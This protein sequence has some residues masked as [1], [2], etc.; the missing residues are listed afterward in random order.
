MT[1]RRFIVILLDLIATV[2]ALLSSFLLRWGWDDFRL[3]SDSILTATLIALPVALASYWAFG[4]A[5]TPWKYFSASDLRRIAMAVWVPALALVAVDYLSKSSILV[6]RTVPTIYWFVQVFLLAGARLMYRSYR[7]QRQ[8]RRAFKGVHRMPVLIAG[9]DDEAENLIRR[10]QRD[11]ARPMEVV[12]LLSPKP[13]QVGERMLGIPVLGSFADL[14]AV[15]AALS[16]RNVQARR[17]IVTRDSLRQ[18]PDIDTLLGAARKVGIAAVRSTDTM[19]EVEEHGA[20]LKLAP[21]SIDD[22]LG[23]SSRDL[24]LSSIRDLVGGRRIAVTGAGGSIGSELCRQIA[25][26]QPAGLMLFEQSELA[27]YTI[28]KELRRGTPALETVLHLGSVCDRADI[29]AAF[30]SFRP[31]LVFHAAALKHVDLVE[32]HPV[33][34]ARTNTLGTAYVAEAALAVDARCAVFISTDKA[35]HPVSVLGATKRAGELVWAA[36]DRK[37]QE[38]GR[39]TRFMSVRFGNVLGSSGSVIPLFTEQLVQGGPITVTDPEVERYFMTISEAV[40]LVLMASALGV[41]CAGPAPTFV[42]DMGEPIKIVD[43]ARRM[44]RLAG[45]EPDRDIDVVFTGLRPGERLREV[46]E[47]EGETLTPTAI[48]GVQSTA[49]RAPQRTRLDALLAKLSAALSANDPAGVRHVLSDLVP[50]Y[51]EKARTAV[52]PLRPPGLARRDQRQP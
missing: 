33:A 45:L 28:S 13:R 6:P 39:P 20:D 5:S 12:G 29:V 32:A 49:S 38:A 37:A 30:E 48:P 2:A 17:M 23:R 24:D 25:A 18:T 31:E 41:K 8:E 19:A 47:H 22:L 42:L 21:V 4:L 14:E 3:Q 35:V 40:T 43:L 9:A 16:S 46:L 51:P 15:Q 11:T 50:D 27:L 26:M 1:V 52:I 34:A 44:I 36:C 7:R 10:L